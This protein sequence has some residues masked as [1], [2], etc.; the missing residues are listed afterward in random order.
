MAGSDNPPRKRR[1][2]RLTGL[3][4]AVARSEHHGKATMRNMAISG[5]SNSDPKTERI[6]VLDIQ[7]TMPEEERVFTQAE[8]REARLQGMFWGAGI[9]IAIM[10]GFWI[11][12]ALLRAG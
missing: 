1:V 9:G 12:V 8:L 3:W 4:L 11:L 5:E 2:T 7:R 6:R 10:G